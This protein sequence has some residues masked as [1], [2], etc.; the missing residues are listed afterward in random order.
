MENFRFLMNDVLLTMCLG[1]GW[2]IINVYSCL[3][4]D[5]GR[6][7]INVYRRLVMNDDANNQG[8]GEMHVISSISE[9]GYLKVHDH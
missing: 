5:M 8:V 3:L 6:R 7:V 1:L 4:R 2:R 9:A